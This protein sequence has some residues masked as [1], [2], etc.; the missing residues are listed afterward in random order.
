MEKKKYI[1]LL[2]KEDVMEILKAGNI[3]LL[4]D[5]K[6]Y[7]GEKIPSIQIT[8]SVMLCRTK[9]TKRDLAYNMVMDV[10]SFFDKNPMHS[11]AYNPKE[12]IVFIYN[13]SCQV[14]TF[15]DEYTE[16]NTN[17]T[18][19]LKEILSQKDKNYL[20]DFEGY[21][22]RDENTDNENDGE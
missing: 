15:G 1:K 21:W 19:K 3:S 10:L 7:S 11:S 5:S 2:T 6:T 8:G 20:Q 18:L 13:Y 12:M 4:P 16:E 22:N 14:A 17:M 9:V